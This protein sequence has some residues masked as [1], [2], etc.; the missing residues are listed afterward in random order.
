MR[1]ANE[2]FDWKKDSNEFLIWLK[3]TLKGFKEEKRLL[4]EGYQTKQGGFVYFFRS[5]SG[6]YKIG[7][8]KDPS[9]RLG[10]LKG[11]PAYQLEIVHR[12]LTDDMVK[13]E[14]FL[15]KVFSIQPHKRIERE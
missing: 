14:N 1:D 8:S 3:K 13:L 6:N 9:I 10:Q 2:T 4:A 11:D 12:I 15:H 7:R 5:S